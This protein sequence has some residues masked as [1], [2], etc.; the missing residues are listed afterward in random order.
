MRKKSWRIVYIAVYFNSTFFDKKS[1]PNFSWKGNPDIRNPGIRNISC[2]KYKSGIFY[3]FRKK[4]KNRGIL[5]DLNRNSKFFNFSYFTI[6]GMFSYNWIFLLFLRKNSKSSVKSGPKNS[7]SLLYKS[8]PKL[9]IF[10]KNLSKGVLPETMR[11]G[12]YAEVER[13]LQAKPLPRLD[14]TLLRHFFPEFGP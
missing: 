14:E 1:N 7:N 3:L 2:Q 6:F 4:L 5:L 12:P 9:K 10:F 13:A 8:F 11:R